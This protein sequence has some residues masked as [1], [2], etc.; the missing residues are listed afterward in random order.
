MHDQPTRGPEMSPAEADDQ[1]KAVVLNHLL[2]VY[3][4]PFT[5]AEL[6][7]ELAGPTAKSSDQ[8]DVQRAVRDLANAGLLHH[9]GFFVWPTRA[10]QHAGY[11]AI[12]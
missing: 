6:M 9:S 3:P 5:I 12:C 7:S 4:A 10:A 2:D 1:M 11:L 8:D